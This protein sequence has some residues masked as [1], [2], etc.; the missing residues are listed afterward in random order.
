MFD[1]EYKVYDEVLE[2]MKNKTK[3]IEV[4]LYN[5]K[6]SRIKIGDIIKF[7]SVNDE[8]KCV[9]VKVNNLIMYDNVDDFLEKLDFKMATK[10]HNKEN[11][12]YTL[13]N[14]FGK[15]EVNTHKLIG[16]EFELIN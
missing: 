6:S 4:R 8:N 12:L 13:Y 10:V 16:I 14:I 3:N 1:F 11:A 5:E 7:K 2:A 15:E 9:L